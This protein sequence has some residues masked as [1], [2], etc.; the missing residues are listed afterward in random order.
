MSHEPG[1]MGLEPGAKKT[2]SKTKE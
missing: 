1:A 2:K